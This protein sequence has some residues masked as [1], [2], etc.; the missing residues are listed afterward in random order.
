[1]ASVDYAKR[2]CIV[3]DSAEEEAA[4]SAIMSGWKGSLH[5]RQLQKVRTKQSTETVVWEEPA[6]SRQ[7]SSQS[8]SVPQS[9][10]GRFQSFQP[11]AQSA[12]M[13]GSQVHNA[14]NAQ[15]VPPSQTRVTP[16]ITQTRPVDERAAELTRTL[17]REG[18]PDEVYQGQ[19]ARA[20]HNQPTTS[21][22]VDS[23]ASSREP[24][25]SELF[26][27]RGATLPLNDTGARP[28]IPSPAPPTAD[29]ELRPAPLQTPPSRQLEA[30][31]ESDATRSRPSPR[32]STD[33]TKRQTRQFG[34]TGRFSVIQSPVESVHSISPPTRPGRS[35]RAH[36]NPR[37]RHRTE[38]PETTALSRK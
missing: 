35:P 30:N 37:I 25:R 26:L 3:E 36:H 9:G 16:A 24:S 14:V 38:P 15:A 7:S 31:P 5:F 21:P 33:E 34:K 1:M 10:T 12:M 11:G 6:L 22:P 18:I 19:L 27:D 23:N 4:R 32:T 17:S 28:S 29:D 8:L 2:I 13:D 20:A